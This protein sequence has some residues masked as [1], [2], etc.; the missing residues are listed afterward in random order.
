MEPNKNIPDVSHLCFARR[1]REHCDHYEEEGH[2]CDCKAWAPE[3]CEKRC[4]QRKDSHREE[5]CTPVYAGDH[6]YYPMF[7]LIVHLYNQRVFS[8]RTFGPP[9][10]GQ[11]PEGVLRHIEKEVREL[12]VD[13]TNLEEWVDM[14]LLS[15]DGAIKSGHSPEEISTMLMA[16]QVKNESREWPDWRTGDLSQSIEHVRTQEEQQAKAQ[17]EASLSQ[18]PLNFDGNG[19]PV[20]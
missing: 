2:C 5:N 14:M 17:E 3:M 13:P 6:S 19:S 20:S 7:N 18:L 1:D 16:K 9:G 8:I 12:R 4:G 11:K 15:M 10:Q